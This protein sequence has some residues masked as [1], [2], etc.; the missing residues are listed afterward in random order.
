MGAILRFVRDGLDLSGAIDDAVTDR[1]RRW[2]E[3]GYKAS[4][5]VAAGVPHQR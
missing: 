5:S 2:P 4:P 3:W 1:G